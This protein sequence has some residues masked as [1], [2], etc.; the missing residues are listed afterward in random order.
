MLF[1]FRLFVLVCSLAIAAGNV[2][3]VEI[4]YDFEGAETDFVI[5]KRTTDGSQDGQIFQNV[6]PDDN[7][8]PAFGSESA[9]FDIPDP[10]VAVPP[11]STLEIPDSTLGTDFAL[12]LAAFIKNDEDPQNFTRA[13]SSYAG[14]G[15]VS[16]ERVLLDF[17]SRGSSIPGIRA[18]IG[19]TQVTTVEPPA[20][21]S[22]P[23]YHHYAMTVEPTV[24]GGNVVVYFNGVEVASGS[25]PAGYSNIQ[26]I[27]L[28]EDPHDI[29]GSANEQLIGNIDEVLMLE[30]ALS[31]TDIAALAGGA[32]VSSVVTP[33]ASERA[34]YYSFEGDSGTTVTDSFT[35]DGSQDGIAHEI[36]MVD[37]EAANARLG[38]ASFAT[39]DPRVGNPDV[40]HSVVET[41]PLGV[42]GPQF[43]ISA[44]INPL[45]AG[46]SGNAFSRVLSTYGGGGSTAG[47]FILDFNL[48]AAEETDAIRLFL[49][50]G[51]RLNSTT[52]PQIGVNQTLTAVYDYGEVKL[53]LDG[54][55]IASASVEA[56]S[57]DFGDFALRLGED[58]G[59][60]VNENFLGNMD[61]VLIIQQALSEQQVADLHTSGGAALLATLP[62]PTLDGDYNDDGVI[63]LAD[64][65]VWRNN[66]GSSTSL[67]NDSTPGVDEG[68]YTVWK[69]NFGL[70]NNLSASTSITGVPEP[71]S[72]LLLTGAAVLLHGFWRRVRQFTAVD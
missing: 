19:N 59:G 8:D 7:F 44:V 49:P 5:D 31:P 47:R 45:G 1:R 57:M 51:T 64:Y 15:P 41:G 42:M 2:V 53:Y 56:T 55:E 58:I 30:R 46:H 48:N 17:D 4:F 61:D 29:G 16:T 63:N 32:A 25:V 66:L 37:T 24:D 28:G 54:V 20:G 18:I 26:N 13:F 69:L 60:G 21:M 62:D 70:S 10:G 50:D 33:M 23:G 67:P 34:V 12:T 52:V 72:V 14:T 39:Q 27:R 11:Y 3:A 9:L 36:A 43:T 22:D 40:L 65:V 6:Y 68:D 35:V 71:N 38:S